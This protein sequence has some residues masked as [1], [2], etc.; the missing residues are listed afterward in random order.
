MHPF[1][2]YVSAVK[3]FVN[4]NELDQSEY[5]RLG[6]SEYRWSIF[7]SRS[8]KKNI[9]KRGSVYQFDFGKNTVPE[10][11]YEHRGL[12]IGTNKNLLYVLPIFTYRQSAHTK[13]LYDPTT[14]RGRAGNLFLLRASE[15]NFINMI[16]F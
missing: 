10:M 11:S 1:D 12:V 15:H 2:K 14:K 6:Q 7:R 3:V 5:M 8:F 9:V 4:I 13:D 16:Q